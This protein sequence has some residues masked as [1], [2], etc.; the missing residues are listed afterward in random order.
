[1]VVLLS[2]VCCAAHCRYAQFADVPQE[3]ATK[4]AKREAILRGIVKERQLLKSRDSL[5]RL[6]QVAPRFT[7]VIE[8]RIDNYLSAMP[9]LVAGRAITEIR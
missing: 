1:M 4:E 3:E 6:D 2:L 5:L 9:L 7:A 8:E